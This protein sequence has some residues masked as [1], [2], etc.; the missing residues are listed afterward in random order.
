MGKINANFTPIIDDVAADADIGVI[1]A[2]VYGV[3]WR[4]CQMED[5][6]CRVSLEKLAEQCHTSRRTVI[7]HLKRLCQKGYIKDHT[8]KVRNKPH[9]YTITE[10]AS[11][12]L[13]MTGNNDVGVTE[14]HSKTGDRSDRESLPQC[15]KVTPRSDRESLEET[16]EETLE[17]R[18]GAAGGAPVAQMRK[19]YEQEIGLVTSMVNDKFR[20]YARDKVPLF[21]FEYAVGEAVANGAR[22]LSYV[23]KIVQRLR[24]EGWESVD[25]PS[26]AGNGHRSRA[27]ARHE[28]AE[29]QE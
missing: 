16:L 26:D 25:K 13:S 24:I 23:D 2:L 10:K 9:K 22:K 12:D 15:Q 21:A 29:C 3:V 28:Y 5:A 27:P 7:R 19:I 4:W 17:E 1:G 18:I 14:S 8:P 6:E 20:E 11:V